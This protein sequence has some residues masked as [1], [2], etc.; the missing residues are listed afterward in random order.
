MDQVK[1][2]NNPEAP[3]SFP[4]KRRRGRPRK[5]PS[6][7]V[8]RRMSAQM[9]S[10]LDRVSG[11]K[12]FQLDAVEDSYNGVV[13][14]PV[15]GVVESSFDAGY[16]LSVRIGNSGTNLRGVVFKPG[17]Y[18]PISAENDVAPHVQMI[19]RNEISLPLVNQA[20]SRGRHRRSRGRNA[21]HVSALQLSNS[22][23]PSMEERGNLV[24]VVLQPSNLA[25]GMFSSQAPQVSH[26]SGQ[27]ADPRY[28]QNQPGV[29]NLQPSMS[30]G[31]NGS[32][33]NEGG[34]SA[35]HVAQGEDGVDG[36]LS[37]EDSDDVEE[38][39]DVM[40]LQ[41]IHTYVH[42]QQPKHVHKPIEVQRPG[43]MTELLQ[44]VQENVSG[45]PSLEA[46]N[47]TTGNDN[48]QA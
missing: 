35:P 6:Q 31:E 19:R 47:L 45:N 34:P 24:P 21:R 26:L 46:K 48:A 8:T 40:P 5:D 4:V 9:S 30:Q 39:L 44:A 3:S 7:G 43:K 14:Q 28:I 1:E 23:V 33:M 2:E 29:S 16:L 22:I 11:T 32:F 38:P 25:N 18:I 15:T 20:S 17:H 27:Y 41:A 12:S 36:K 10:G 42:N 13:G 37:G